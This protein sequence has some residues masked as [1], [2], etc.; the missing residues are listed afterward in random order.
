M[1]A[2]SFHTS[3]S[4]WV[5]GDFGLAV[6]ICDLDSVL[7]EDLT[8]SYCKNT[9]IHTALV[10]VKIHV[11][12]QN[13]ISIGPKLTYFM[14]ALAKINMKCLNRNVYE[15]CHC[16]QFF[17]WKWIM[18]YWKLIWL[19]EIRFLD[20]QYPMKPLHVDFLQ[21][22]SSKYYYYSEIKYNLY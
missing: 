7:D 12:F 13:I 22:I 11:L 21:F 2:V 3:W 5:L 14:N 9:F 4:M 15:C 6:F 10:G 16:C 20:N 19:L 17:F 8:L 18:T 1:P